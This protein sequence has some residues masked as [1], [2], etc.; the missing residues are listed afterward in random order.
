MTPRLESGEKLV[1]LVNISYMTNMKQNISDTTYLTA[2]AV[3]LFVVFCG[4]GCVG[5]TRKRLEAAIGKAFLRVLKSAVLHV[6]EKKCNG[7]FFC[8]S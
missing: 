7:N 4:G 5:F 1:K 2:V 3:E 6:Q 8:D